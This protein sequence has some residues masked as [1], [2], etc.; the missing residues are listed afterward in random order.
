MLNNKEKNI[1]YLL[2]NYS[3]KSKEEIIKDLNL[4]WSYIQKLACLNGIK[5]GR[6]ES[7]NDW[8]FKKLIDY[9]LRICVR[10]NDTYSLLYLVKKLFYKLKKHKYGIQT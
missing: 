10:F 4:S 1:N 3:V 2:E 7:P 5:K 6:N 8:K 9:R